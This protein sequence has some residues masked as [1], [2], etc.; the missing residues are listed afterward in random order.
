M[1]MGAVTRHKC[2]C[3]ETSTGSLFKILCCLIGAQTYHG[4]DFVQNV[5]SLISEFYSN[6]CLSLNDGTIYKEGQL[7]YNK[8][9]RLMAM[10][11]NTLK[12]TWLC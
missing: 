6:Y 10:I 2:S 11:K 8:A 12:E 4:N 1:P 3:T 9:A 5:L 7:D